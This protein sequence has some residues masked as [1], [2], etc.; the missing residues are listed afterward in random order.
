MLKQRVITAVVLLAIVLA[1]LLSPAAWPFIGLA[2]LM[3]AAGVWE[4]GRLNG[5]AG[6]AALGLGA[7]TALAGA[8]AWRLGWPQ[9]DLGRFW[10]GA[11]VV[12]LLAIAWLL[13]GGVAAWGRIAR[14]A[15]LAGGVL[16]LLLAWLAI[17]QARVQGV[18]LLLS[19][20]VL[21]WTADVAAYFVGRAFGQKFFARKLAPALSPGKSWEGA[22]GGVLAVLAVGVVWAVL[23]GA[24]GRSL[25]ARLASGGAVVFGL[26]LVL[27]TFVS[28]AGDLIESLVKRS[29]GAK[30]SSQL[31]PGHGGV[32]DRVDALLP[33]FPVAM[34]LLALLA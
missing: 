34:M 5:L 12:W 18:A 17:S 7:A 10:L 13:Q 31:L 15:R 16:A 26:A 32:L 21:V 11:G 24:G 20:C 4:W 1:A 25:F 27:L 23:E 28:I 29:A 8:L 3:V 9:A 6:G 19:I 33:T 14:A 2:L 22:L 30:D